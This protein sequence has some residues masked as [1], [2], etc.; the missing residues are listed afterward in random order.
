VTIELRAAP[1]AEVVAIEER[2]H[3]EVQWVQLPGGLSIEAFHARLSLVVPVPEDGEYELS[4]LSTGLSRLYVGDE[5]VVDNWEGWRQGG[6]PV[7]LGSLE[8]RCKRRLQAGAIELVAEY[9]PRRFAEGVAHLQAIR[10]GFGRPLPP[11]SVTEAAT[12]AAAADCA[13]VCIGTAA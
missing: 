3:G 7:G 8:A 12:I 5:L 1:G 11:S 13:I 2:P 10:I 4:V 6:F 9:G